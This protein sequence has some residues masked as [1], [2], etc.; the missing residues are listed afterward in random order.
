[1]EER[2]RLNTM[3]QFDGKFAL[4]IGGIDKEIFCKGKTFHM[5]PP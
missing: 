5:N 4:D 2:I 1:M 3:T